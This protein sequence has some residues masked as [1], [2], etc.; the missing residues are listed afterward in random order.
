MNFFKKIKELKREKALAQ[1][2]AIYPEVNREIKPIVIETK[3]FSNEQRKYDKIAFEGLELLALEHL[4]NSSELYKDKEQESDKL[5]TINLVMKY[6]I[7]DLKFRIVSSEITKTF[8]S[9]MSKKESLTE[10]FIKAKQK[11]DDFITR[12]IQSNLLVSII[13]IQT[14]VYRIQEFY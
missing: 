13:K 14:N 11:I 6:D 10:L 7:V 12:T 8:S 3:K 2:L 9:G 4:R 1:L 5:Q